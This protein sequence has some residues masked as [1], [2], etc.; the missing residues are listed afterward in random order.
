MNNFSLEFNSLPIGHGTNSIFK[1]S[2][3]S[4]YIL[5]L[6]DFGF[7]YRIQSL[8]FTTDNSNLILHFKRFCEYMRILIIFSKQII[9]LILQFL[10]KIFINGILSC[11]LAFILEIYVCLQFTDPFLVHLWLLCFL[12]QVLVQ[13]LDLVVYCLQSVL[14][15]VAT[16]FSVFW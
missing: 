4:V 7:E 9:I 16:F 13:F 14:E 2:V 3:D 8:I 10:N 5:I 11:H 6:L 15:I 12:F 1:F